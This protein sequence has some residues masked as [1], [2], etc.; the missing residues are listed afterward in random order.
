MALTRVSSD[1]QDTYNYP[2]ICDDIGSQFDGRRMIFTL[3]ANGNTINTI[4]DSKNVQVYLN[5][6][7]QRPYIAEPTLPWAMDYTPNGFYKIVG[8]TIIFY[9]PPVDSDT[10]MIVVVTNST[11]PQV[12]SNF[13]SARTIALGD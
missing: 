1:L 7:I 3:R 2:L 4:V 12:T 10:V 8:N 13:Y 6:Q 11:Y 9:N 5:G